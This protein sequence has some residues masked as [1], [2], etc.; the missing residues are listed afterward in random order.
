MK[1]KF[2]SDEIAHIW[3]HK[4]APHGTSPGAMSFNG[5]SF[6]SYG[7]VISR[8]ITFKGKQAIILNDTSY[9]VS[10]S[11]HQG[12][13]RRAIPGCVPVF[14]IGDIGRGCSLNFDG[15]EGK[16]L[17]EYA[18]AQ[19]A[20]SLK[21]SE[22][23]KARKPLYEA[24]AARWLERAKEVNQFFGLRRKVDEKT[25][26]RL[27]A[28]SEKAEREATKKRAE[29]AEKRRIEQTESFEAWKQNREH[30]YFDR[31]LFPVA[32]RIEEDELVSSKGARV[33]LEAARVAIRFV[34]HNR[35]T[36]WHR[37]GTSCQVGMYHLDSVNEH[38]V[39]AGCHRISWEEVE[40]VAALLA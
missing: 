9:S 22:K 5:D 2:K 23:A 13:V 17:F 8:H 1:T 28:S 36:G 11:K 24:D 7:T 19:S 10:T 4:Q 3:A 25:I 34:L 20:E 32:F 27:R 29:A 16:V 39:V 33:P 35:S 18:V 26:E 15:R 21:A 30:D 40:R 6:L 12:Y 38:G 37:N 31:S 14:H